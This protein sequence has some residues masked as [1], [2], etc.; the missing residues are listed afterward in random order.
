MI[1]SANE[2]AL[3]IVHIFDIIL[4]HRMDPESSY[5]LEIVCL[6]GDVTIPSTPS[7]SC[8][9]ILERSQ[10]TMP[11]TSQPTLPS[12]QPSTN[13]PADDN[14]IG[15]DIILVNPNPHNEHVGIDDEGEYLSPEQSGPAHI[16]HIEGSDSN[17]ASDS[18]SDE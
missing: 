10:S 16:A 9:V 6:S 2:Y 3:L 12:M 4:I 14:I 13:E 18:A 1:K 17:C 15:D 7:M 11:S 8:P 5:L